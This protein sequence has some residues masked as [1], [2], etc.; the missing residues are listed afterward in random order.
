MDSKSVQSDFNPYRYLASEGFLPGY[1]FPRLP[2]AAYVP[3]PAAASRDGDYLQR[4]RFLAIREFGPG[5]LIYHEGARYQV[6]RIQLPPDAAG[7]V[8]TGQ[9]RSCAQCGYHHEIAKGNADR[10]Q[11]CDA[12]L[13]ETSNGLLR[14]HTVY[15]R[16][17]ERIS[18]DEEERRR[19]GLPPGHLV[20]VPR[21]RRPPR[22]PGRHRLRLDA[23]GLAT[24]SYG[25]SAT[26]RITNVGRVP[27]KPG[28]PDG[29]WLDPGDGRWMNERDASE[30]S[31]DSSEMPVVDADG[32]EKR[33]KK[34]SSPTWRTAATS[35]SSSSTR[36]SRPTSR[37]P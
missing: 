16:R 18:S 11:M 20:P 33:R 5:A 31:G 28:E 17:R 8:V 1:S 7:D 26:V 27:A 29:F 37:S 25:D 10:C 23:S 13:G 24:L 30:A 21:P 36:R 14:L 12:P 32:N 9:A 4:P 34:G 35:S 15:T 6:T 19:A 3:G 2:L 22:P